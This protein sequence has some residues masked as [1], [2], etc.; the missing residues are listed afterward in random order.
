MAKSYCGTLFQ[1]AS[2]LQ[3]PGETVSARLITLPTPEDACSAFSLN[4]EVA[5][6]YYRRRWNTGAAI[7]LRL[8]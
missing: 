6:H 2:G 7:R 8:Y 3:Q 4:L 5:G 1:S